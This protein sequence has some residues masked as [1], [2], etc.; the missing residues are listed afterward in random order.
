MDTLDEKRILSAI[1]M[2]RKQQQKPDMISISTY[3]NRKYGPSKSAVTQTIDYM[4]YSAAMYCTALI[5][6]DS[7][8][9]FDPLNLYEYEDIDNET[10]CLHNQEPHDVVTWSKDTESSPHQSVSP[11][12][13]TSRKHSSE[14]RSTKINKISQV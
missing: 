5:G 10:D 7:Y 3:L 13:Q 12:I 8:Y 2:I 11:M 1:H 14:S 6:K 9:I 4:V